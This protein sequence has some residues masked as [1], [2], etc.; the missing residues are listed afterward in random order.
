MYILFCI[1]L[2]SLRKITYVSGILTVYC[3][4]IYMLSSCLS[5]LPLCDFYF[6][7]FFMNRSFSKLNQS[8]NTMLLCMRQVV[9]FLTLFNQYHA[10]YRVYETRTMTTAGAFNCLHDIVVRKIA[11]SLFETNTRI[12]TIRFCRQST[13]NSSSQQENNITHG[14]PITFHHLRSMNITAEQLFNWNAPM[15]TIEDYQA[16]VQIGLFVNCS[17]DDKYWFG[18]NCEY[19]FDSSSYFPDIVDG[20]FGEKQSVPG[21]LLTRDNSVC[22]ETGGVECQSVLCLDW[23]EICDGKILIAIEHNML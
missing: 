20:Q 11:S 21:D 12:H 4:N 7:Q 2:K 5:L 1:R 15:D 9:V 13:L 22:L 6:K 3:A 19:S 18:P 23:R 10:S 14:T 8:I 16:G 17:Q